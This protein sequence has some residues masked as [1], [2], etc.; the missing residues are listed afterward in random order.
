MKDYENG[1]LFQP[2][3]SGTCLPITKRNSEQNLIT[4]N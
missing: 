3:F 2:D 4:L 1:G